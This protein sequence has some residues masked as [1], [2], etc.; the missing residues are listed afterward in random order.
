MDAILGANGGS[1]GAWE[2]PEFTIVWRKLAKADRAL[3]Y[4]P[5]LVGITGACPSGLVELITPWAPPLTLGTGLC[6]GRWLLCFF[7]FLVH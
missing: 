5:W 7:F 3:D 4:F 1:L 6:K 2:Q